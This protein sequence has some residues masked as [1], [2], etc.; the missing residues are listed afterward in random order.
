[1]L[2]ERKSE[3]EDLKRVYRRR[4]PNQE[5]MSSMRPTY[6]KKKISLE[7][8]LQKFILRNLSSFGEPASLFPDSIIY[9]DEI[10]T[11][12]FLRAIFD[13]KS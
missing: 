13:Y 4:I 11:T 1:M 2:E 12:K 10:D 3:R 8:I 6:V 7:Q 9:I 5:S